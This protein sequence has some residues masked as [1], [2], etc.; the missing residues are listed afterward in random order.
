MNVWRTDTPLPFM[1]ALHISAVDMAAV[2]TA[3]GA[4]V[5]RMF[6]AME[7]SMELKCDADNRLNMCEGVW[8]YSLPTTLTTQHSPCCTSGRPHE[9]TTTPGSIRSTDKN[10]WPT[11]HMDVIALYSLFLKLFWIERL[12]C[13]SSYLLKHRR[14]CCKWWQN[15]WVTPKHIH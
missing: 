8:T 3:I 4:L 10:R 1:P 11:L 15:I 9:G 13:T 5:T 2:P 6:H 7:E 12:T 14:P